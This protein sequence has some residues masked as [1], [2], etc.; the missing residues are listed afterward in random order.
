MTRKLFRR[1]FVIIF[2]SIILILSSTIVLNK[3]WRT[4][5]DKLDDT[6]KEML[7]ELSR[8]HER[9]QTESDQLWT[10]N[11]RF[12]NEPLILVRSNKDKGFFPTH[13]YA[14]N[15]PEIANSLFAQ[16][17]DTPKHLNLPN[18]YRINQLHLGLVPWVPWNFGTRHVADAD[19]FYFKY[20]PEMF[21]NPPLY[22]Q[23][24]YFLLHEAFHTY[25]QKTWTYDAEGDHMLDD[26]VD[27]ENYALMGIEFKLLDNAMTATRQEDVRDALRQWT[28]VRTSR[29]EKWPQLVAETKAEAIEGTARYIEYRYSELIGDTLTV[30]ATTEDPY[31][32]QFSDAFRFISDGEAE[33]A[34]FLGR[35]MRYETG[36]ALGLL[37]DK[38]DPEWKEK[39]ED[40][41][42]KSGQTQYEILQTLFDIDAPIDEAELAEI[43]KAHDYETLLEQARKIVALAA[44]EE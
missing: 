5:F 14:I 38:I 20:H 16:K 40:E 42:E 17:I 33:S 30:L 32:I 23:F 31:H 4:S 37:L 9:F 28:I 25:K 21:T 29:Y 7:T 41:P 1:G 11:Y 24:H 43:K 6:D 36:A 34:H 18:V 3:M 12:D 27:E 15:V 22:F 26:P 8:I 39:I 19:V 35:S 44:E 13:A 2:I 10:A